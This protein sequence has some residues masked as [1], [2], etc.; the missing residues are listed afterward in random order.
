MLLLTQ[1]ILLVLYAVAPVAAVALV[2]WRRRR[3]RPSGAIGLGSTVGTSLAL[4]AALNFVYAIVSGASVR[5][6]QILITSYVMLGLILVLRGF[7]WLVQEALNHLFRL[8][9]SEARP[10]RL[11]VTAAALVR[12]ALLFGVGLPWIMAS[13]MV[14]RP[15][16]HLRDD[17][18]RQLGVPYETVDFRATDG[19]A[20]EGWWIPA[21]DRLGRPASNVTE[22]VVVCHGLGANKSN[23][24]TLG[25]HFV[26]AGYNVLIL[27]DSSGYGS[28]LSRSTSVT[29]MRS[30]RFSGAGA[31]RSAGW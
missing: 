5:T 29:E 12:V 2:G 10:G 1:W 17:P 21:I 24:L 19:V 4:G 15:K 8:R 16:V 3:N 26:Q 30:G 18:Q 13:V 20:I 27:P 23:Q 6:G 22:T 11:R 7:H 28:A 31:G 9:S 25:A 14:F